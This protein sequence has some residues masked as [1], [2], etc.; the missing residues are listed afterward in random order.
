[1][2]EKRGRSHFTQCPSQKT[3]DTPDPFS[4]PFS[5]RPQEATAIGNAESPGPRLAG[6]PRWL[7]LALAS[8]VLL[9]AV[10]AVH[11]GIPWAVSHL[12]P[13]YGWADGEPAGWRPVAK[14]R[15][16]KHCKIKPGDEAPLAKLK[17]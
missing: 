3:P 15:I 9:V 12:C 1:M 16:V 6:I 8:V 14:H 11:A 13:R 7:A 5:S 17:S 4:S 10:P 2:K